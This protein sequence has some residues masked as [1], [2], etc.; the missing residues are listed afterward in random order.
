MRTVSVEILGVRLIFWLATE[1]EMHLVKKTLQILNKLPSAIGVFPSPDDLL[2]ALTLQE[3][4]SRLWSFALVLMDSG[5]GNELLDKV[6][7]S[8]VAERM[9]MRPF[10]VEDLGGP[11]IVWLIA[12]SR[13]RRRQDDQFRDTLLGII[14]R[15]EHDDF[16]QAF[17]TKMFPINTF[18]TK[19]V[20]FVP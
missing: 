3:S 2:K 10:F 6:K 16:M 12:E 18:S 14:N 17:M 5:L 8:D 11:F 1:M 20:L 15:L 4:I 7:L 9:F 13:A 19:E